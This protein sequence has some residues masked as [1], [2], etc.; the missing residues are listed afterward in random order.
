MDSMSIRALRLIALT[1]ALIFISIFVF[2]TLWGLYTQRDDALLINIAGRQRMLIHQI[3]LEAL[4]V[5][6]TDDVSSRK[7]LSQ[8][9]YLFKQTLDALQFGGTTKTTNGKEIALSTPDKRDRELIAQLGDARTTWLEL[10]PNIQV[11]LTSPTQSL[12]FIEAMRNL[13]THSAVLLM[14]MNEVVEIYENNSE[15]KVSFVRTIQIGFLGTASIL[16]I[17]S[18]FIIERRVL[19]PIAQLDEVIQLVGQGNLEASVSIAGLGE[20]DRLANNFEDMRLRLKDSVE[21]QIRRT[22]EAE[23]LQ[24]AGAVVAASLR[25][26]EAIERILEQLAYVVTYDSASVLLLQEGYLEIVGGRGWENAAEVVGLRFPIPGDNPNTNVIL[27]RAPLIL[28]DAPSE[29]AAF[30]NEPHSHIRSWMGVPLIVGDRIIGMLSIDYVQPGFYTPDLARLVTAFA[31]QVSIVIENARL[32]TETEQKADELRRLYKATQD[33]ASSLDSPVVLER[34]ACHLTQALEAT[35]GHINIVDSEQK[36]TTV[37]AEY[38]SDQASPEERVSDLGR[39]Y[40]LAEYPLTARAI[41]ENKLLTCFADSEFLSQAEREELMK[42]DIQSEML[43][44]ISTFGRSIGMV[45]IWDSRRRREFTETEKRLAQTLAQHGAVIIQNVRLYAETEKQAGQLRALRDASHALTSNLHIKAVLQTLVETARRLV[46]ASYAA[47]GVMDENGNLSQFHTDGIT[48]EERK[49]IGRAPAGRGILGL[50]IHEG[51][52][53]RLTNIASDPRSI[54]FPPNHPLMN[55]FMGVPIVVRRKVIGSLYITEKTGGQPF[56][57]DDEDLVVGLAADAAIAI[58]NAR[59]FGMVE[60]MA[61]MDG[62]TGLYNR[63]HFLKLAESEFQRAR[64]YNRPLSVIM[65]D[66]DHFKLVNDTYGHA[67]GDQVL[68]AVATRCHEALRANDRIGRYG[69]EEF[70]LLLPENE[71]AGAGY[72]AERLRRLVSE[73]PIQVENQI[74]Y[75]TI[76]LGVAARREDCIDVESLIGRADAALYAAKS[77]GRNRTE[78]WKGQ[79]FQ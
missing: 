56:T 12:I 39:N 43:I 28:S 36:T 63:H 3:Q 2:V 50:L 64:R 8:T 16:L 67:V 6:S 69:G 62:L 77:A 46:N 35:S 66:I 47:L 74:I 23:T 48:E 40:P 24:R 18:F 71:T 60:Q 31:D 5:Q 27:Q 55:T 25:Q 78:L 20:L 1:G 59:L 73:T 57:Q 51:V 26:E 72:V 7:R 10:Y 15:R 75:V 79:A 14:H 54:G 49:K 42:Y 30:R 19:L 41:T 45:Q 34:L 32:F 17:M 61:T 53:I 70:A 9:A 38:W 58:E 22:Q 11:I 68:R 13:E 29:F 37:L 52:P 76:S 44:P 65:L 33:M 21:I 4:D